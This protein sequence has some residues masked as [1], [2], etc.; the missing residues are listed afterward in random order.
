MRCADGAQQ[1][2]A[3]RIGLC[4]LGGV[5]AGQCPGWPATWQ[6]RR[7]YDRN[8]RSGLEPRGGTGLAMND[9]R[10]GGASE[11]FSKT[12][13]RFLPRHH[14]PRRSARSQAG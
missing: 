13:R 12:G 1:G 9:R 3:D 2:G 5:L 8:K 4:G 7:G 6:V 14:H 10:H 11:V